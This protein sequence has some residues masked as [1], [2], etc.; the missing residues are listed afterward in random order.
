MEVSS[1]EVQIIAE[2][3]PAQQITL[4]TSRCAALRCAS[5]VGGTADDLLHQADAKLL[6]NEGAIT[7]GH[8]AG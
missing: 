7:F 3:W 8:H 4:M 5:V 1:N 6:K 2:D